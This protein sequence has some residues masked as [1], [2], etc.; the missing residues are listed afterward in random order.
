[1]EWPSWPVV[2]VEGEEGAV[3]SEGVGTDGALGG[4]S[5]GDGEDCPSG[6]ICGGKDDWVSLFLDRRLEE[7]RAKRER[8]GRGVKDEDCCCGAGWGR[9]WD[10]VA[11]GEIRRGFKGKREGKGGKE[12]GMGRTRGWQTTTTGLNHR[13]ALCWRDG[14]PGHR[15]GG[16]LR[17]MFPRSGVNQI[18][19]RPSFVSG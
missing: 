1:V 5:D 7:D 18:R 4:L 3:A 17:V 10:W 6:L 15:A 8:L 9:S 11:I 2:A 13:V 19:G 14:D 16:W 12:E